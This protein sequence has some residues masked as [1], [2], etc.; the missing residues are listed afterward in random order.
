VAFVLGLEVTIFNPA[1]DRDGSIA[2]ALA[3]CLASALGVSD[4]SVAAGN[5]G[6]GTPRESDGLQPSDGR[7]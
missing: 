4:P 3:T 7:R 6:F 2:R 5:Q 1:L